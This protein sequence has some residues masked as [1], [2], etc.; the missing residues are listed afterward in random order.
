MTRVCHIISGDLWAGAEVMAFNL[1]KGL[2][3]HRDLD[4]FVILLNSGKL[5]KELDKLDIPFFVVEE[6][7]FV[8]SRILLKVRELVRALAPKI[9]HSHR[10]KENLLAYLSGGAKQRTCLISTQHGM[11][12]IFGNNASFKS[13]LIAKMNFFLLAKCFHKVVA[14]STDIRENLLEMS[15]FN[16][17]T[18][19]TIH[20][21][22]PLDGKSVIRNRDTFVIGS[23]GRFVPVKDF[24]FM[25]EVAREI[26]SRSDQIRFELAG[27]GPEWDT[28]R[29]LV[30]KYGLENRFHLRG[31]IEDTASFYSGLD[32]YLN[33]SVHEGIPMSVLEAMGQSVPVI[34]P[35]IGGLSEMIEDGVE[36]YLVKDRDPK[37]FAQ[38]CIGLFSNSGLR[39]KMGEATRRRAYND[40]SIE[41]MARRYY[42]LYRNEVECRP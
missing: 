2:Q 5:A 12:E 13:R 31:F 1:L 25:V 33:T 8:F 35:D 19:E 11:P 40:F 7:K 41:Q 16:K 38:K 26:A 20:N 21:G 32:L 9:I 17:D 3:A 39:V 37:A 36:G 18:V 42:H 34:A 22:I 30:N 10:Y 28:I 14:V 23:C 29:Q 24:P 27:D 4:I 6:Q 15:L